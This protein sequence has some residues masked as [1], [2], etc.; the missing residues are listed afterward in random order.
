MAKQGTGVSVGTREKPEGPVPVT[1]GL[2]LLCSLLRKRRPLGEFVSILDF[3]IP[4]PIT[5]G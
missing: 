4:G 3:V 2:S 5:V 1:A